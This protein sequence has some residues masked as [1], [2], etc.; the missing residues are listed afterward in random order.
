MRAKEKWGNDGEEE[1]GDE[2]D[3]TEGHELKVE[4]KEGEKDGRH[5]GGEASITEAFG[6][7]MRPKTR[8]MWWKNRT[9]KLVI[10]EMISEMLISI[11]AK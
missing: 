11:I 9:E 1:I 8:K 5:S 3:K 10:L 7:V 6:K 2:R 4:A